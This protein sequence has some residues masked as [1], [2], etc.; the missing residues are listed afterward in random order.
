[1]N[2][3]RNKAQDIK[4]KTVATPKYIEL[5]FQLTELMQ[6]QNEFLKQKNK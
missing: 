1:M 6:K 2:Q 5:L 3:L 4:D